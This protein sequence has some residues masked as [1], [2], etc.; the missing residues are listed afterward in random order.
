MISVTVDFSVFVEEQICRGHDL[1]VNS[2]ACSLVYTQ[3]PCDTMMGYRL[4]AAIPKSIHN[5]LTGVMSIDC[6]CHR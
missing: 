6:H 5:T 1:H 4:R 2:F 3:D